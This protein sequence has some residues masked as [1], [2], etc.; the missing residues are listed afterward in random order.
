MDKPIKYFISD[1]HL[2]HGKVLI[3]PRKEY[4]PTMEDWNRHILNEMQKCKS[5]ILYILGDLSME[6]PAKWRNKLPKCAWLI[7]GNHDGS[8]QKC[9]SSFGKQFAITREVKIGPKKERCWLSHY[10]HAFWPASHHGSYHLYGH[11]HDQREDTLDEWMPER[12][13]MDVSPETIFR[14]I[15]EFRPI[16]E[17]EVLDILSKRKGHDHVSFYKGRRGEYTEEV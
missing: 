6:E 5:G 15:G 16:S 8:M 12:R 7:H 1:P 13:S 3:G 9:L 4:F 14:L 10:A 11:T 17:F 2:G